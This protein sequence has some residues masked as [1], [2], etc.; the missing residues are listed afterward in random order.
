MLCLIRGG[1]REKFDFKVAI[2][3]SCLLRNAWAKLSDIH[4]KG[5]REF[6]SLYRNNPREVMSNGDFV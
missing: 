1:T 5:V 2:E 6:R 4:I 3:I